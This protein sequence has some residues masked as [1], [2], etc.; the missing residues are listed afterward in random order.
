MY[1]LCMQYMYIDKYYNY[2]SQKVMMHM[3]VLH[4]FHKDSRSIHVT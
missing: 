1:M 3:V 2:V 4:G